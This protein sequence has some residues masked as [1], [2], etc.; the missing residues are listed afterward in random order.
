MARI[1]TARPARPSFA[2][3]GARPTAGD[4]LALWTA[5]TLAPGL[6]VRQNLEAPMA[7]IHLVGVAGRQEHPD[8]GEPRVGHDCGDQA[9][10][11]P[12]AAPGLVDEDVA[13]PAERRLVGDN[14]G[15]P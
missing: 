9:R 4:R 14:P 3:P 7:P 10:P 1:G 15:E 11:D 8:R 13:D 2:R 5:R 12:L 6:W